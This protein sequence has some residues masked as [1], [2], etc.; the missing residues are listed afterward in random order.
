M[1]NIPMFLK[2]KKDVVH[3]YDHYTLRQTLEKMEVYRFSAM[4]IIDKEGRYIGT[5]TEGDLLYAIKNIYHLDLKLAENVPLSAIPRYKDNMPVRIDAKVEDL[6][7][8]LM[9]QN[10]IPVLDDRGLFI[11][12]VTRKAVLT[13]IFAKKEAHPSAQA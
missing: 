8:I 7:D 11:G 1:L 3:L 13:E 10:F 12:I 2:P 5:I 4:P 6:T 9:E